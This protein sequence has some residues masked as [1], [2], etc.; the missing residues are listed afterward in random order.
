VPTQSDL[1]DRLADCEGFEWDTWNADKVWQRHQV[2]TT[3]CEE[4]F[5]NH[6]LIVKI[7][8]AHSD[9]EDRFYAVGSSDIG[10]L[11]FV[12]FTVRRRLIRVIS[13]RDMS[14]RE[15]RIFR[16]AI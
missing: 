16:P 11:L 8:A 10:R 9:S 1:L 13:A 6:P 14:R 12:A 2:S 7:D 4:L 15:R 5:L 3:E